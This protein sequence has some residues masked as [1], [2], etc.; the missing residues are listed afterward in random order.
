[1][2]RGL[3]H[4]LR[5]YSDVLFVLIVLLCVCVCV[6]VCVGHWSSGL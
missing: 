1:M 4:V 3:E 6:C 5:S 2:A